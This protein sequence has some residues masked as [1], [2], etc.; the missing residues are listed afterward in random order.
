MAGQIRSAITNAPPNSDGAERLRSIQD[1]FLN[2]ATDEERRDLVAKFENELTEV[3]TENRQWKDTGDT[4]RAKAM[5]ALARGDFTTAEGLINELQESHPEYGH[6]L[7]EERRK[8]LK[9]MNAEA[10]GAAD[11]VNDQVVAAVKALSGDTLQLFLG[12]KSEW[13]TTKVTPANL[14]TGAPGKTEVTLNAHAIARVDA[15]LAET[16]AN[17]AEALRK[18]EVFMGAI[19]EGKL[20][21]ARKIATDKAIEYIRSTV[22]TER[23]REPVIEGGS[24]WKGSTRNPFDD[25][26]I[27]VLTNPESLK[28]Q[29]GT[30]PPGATQAPAAQPTSGQGATTIAPTPPAPL[31]PQQVRQVKSNLPPPPPEMGNYLAQF[32]RA[33]GTDN[34]NLHLAKP[35]GIAAFNNARLMATPGTLEAHSGGTFSSTLDS[36]VQSVG[37]AHPV[38][39]GMALSALGAN[40]TKSGKLDEVRQYRRMYESF[41]SNS[42]ALVYTKAA[43]E[44]WQNVE[45]PSPTATGMIVSAFAGAHIPFKGMKASKPTFKARGPKGKGFIPIKLDISRIDHNLVSFFPTRKALDE[46]V[47][48]DGAGIDAVAALFKVDRAEFVKAQ[49]ALLTDRPD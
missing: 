7:V 28:R 19:F 38:M 46:A 23:W 33:A 37:A 15:A 31:P 34:I 44:D 29:V 12:T 35:F 30:Q 14:R 21:A 5:A 10:A 17:L 22:D 25:F 20:T 8:L 47:R 2:A 16:S 49:R 43:R 32:K 41:R 13:V 24:R 36:H 45:G 4:Q 9:G 1:Q 27:E 40:V 48:R 26:V 11:I 3:T 6:D 18:D 42:H 39:Y